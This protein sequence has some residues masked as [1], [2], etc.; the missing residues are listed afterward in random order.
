MMN[1]KW[2]EVDV[3]ITMLPEEGY[4][5]TSSWLACVQARLGDEQ[6]NQMQ[7]DNHAANR[8]HQRWKPH[9]WKRKII[10]NRT[11]PLK[12]IKQVQGGHLL[13]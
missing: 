1:G 9:L 5:G 10:V 3:I 13:D 6:V 2:E 4:V 7:L 11:G 8:N 12:K